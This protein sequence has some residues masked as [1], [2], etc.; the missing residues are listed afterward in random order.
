MGVRRPGTRRCWAPRERRG[1]GP[2]WAV[3]RGERRRVPRSIAAGLWILA[4]T[5][6]S[7]DIEQSRCGEP[8]A[9]SQ[10]NARVHPA[11]ALL[12][13][14]GGR[15][16]V[17][18]LRMGSSMCPTPPLH[19]EAQAH[20]PNTEPLEERPLHPLPSPRAIPPAQQAK[21]LSIG[22]ELHHDIALCPSS[23]N[24]VELRG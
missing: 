9:A 1:R 22:H 23:N 8:R 16:R 13:E 17:C 10:V 21:V 3:S 14:R 2:S 12:D 20:L 11:E 6:R 4:G 7:I 15:T 19:I 24:Q 18:N 5:W